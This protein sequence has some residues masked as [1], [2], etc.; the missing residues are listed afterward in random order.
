[1]Q[2]IILQTKTQNKQTGIELLRI[3]AMLWIIMF[4]YADHGIID[5]IKVPIS[6]NWI[7][8]A[9]AR[10]GGGYWQL[11]ICFNYRISSL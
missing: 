1:M 3:I 2:N 5:M 9:F 6:V 11:Y 7:I 4:H 8:L 10:L